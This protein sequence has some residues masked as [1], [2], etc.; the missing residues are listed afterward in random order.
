M[1][2]RRFLAALPAAT[3]LAGCSG[4]DAGQPTV[5]TTGE[6]TTTS[7]ASV[8]L[9][10][11]ASFR[12]VI[13]DDGIR[14]VSPDRD[15]F[16]FIAPPATETELAPDRFTLALG[17]DRFDPRVIK[18]RGNPTWTPGVDSLYTS[19][20][21][22]GML[23]FDV[24]SVEVDAASLLVNDATHP[25]EAADRERLA[26]APDLTLESVSVPDSVD[27]DEPI[28][29]GITV[30]N[31]GDREGLYLAGFR[32]GGLPETIDVTVPPGEKGSGS[33]EYATQ[34]AESMFFAF[35]F[36]GGDRNYE[37]EIE[38]GTATP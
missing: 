5:S 1:R 24:P 25:I 37:V 2:R 29:L 33:V 38:D 18:T 27:R 30:G 31:D 4:D 21:T 9:T 16:A 36:P 34:D 28:E 26:S 10:L 32:S 15:Q 11:R 19:E 3:A 35:S 7:T 6:R 20:R 13:N 12:H 17:Q 22:G 8:S 23:A 14:V